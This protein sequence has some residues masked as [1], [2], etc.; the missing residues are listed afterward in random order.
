MFGSYKKEIRAQY[1]HPPAHLG[2]YLIIT[3]EV[4]SFK[5]LLH[6]STELEIARCKEWAEW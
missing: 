6:M 2:F 1:M 3:S 4:L 5:M